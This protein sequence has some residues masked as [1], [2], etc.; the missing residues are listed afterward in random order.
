M[1]EHLEGELPASFRA[2]MP[3]HPNEPCPPAAFLWAAASGELSGGDLES[4]TGHLRTCSLCGEALAV[5]ADL[6]TESKA[7][8]RPS[9]GWRTRRLGP[10]MA[11]V[12]ALAA[13][14]LLFHG[15]RRPP[16]AE[17]PAG[18]G[19]VVA[20]RAGRPAEPA[21]RALSKEQQPASDIRLEWTPIDRAV[22]YRVHL[23]TEDLQPVYERILE[24][25]SVL[26]VPK[27]VGDK[28][29]AGH[30]RAVAAHK[31]G[32]GAGETLLWQVE[33]LLPDGKTVSSPTFM[34]H[35]LGASSST[36]R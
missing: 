27:A 14:I 12:T 8:A 13:G 18:P 34:V 17:G 33:A 36:G 16:P 15:Q 2:S 9:L 26:R 7:L 24:Q 20:S 25:E 31:V 35:V 1:P 5:T 10:V 32:G 29:A 3:E 6:V 4:L 21:I 19:E 22:R 23:S 30:E 11:G 28:L